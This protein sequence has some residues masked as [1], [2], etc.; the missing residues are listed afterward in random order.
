VLAQML[1]AH[2]QSRRLR[3]QAALGNDARDSGYFKEMRRLRRPFVVFR[4][5]A[6]AILGALG[7]GERR[8]EHLGRSSESQ[9]PTAVGEL[10]NLCPAPDVPQAFYEKQARE[11][12]RATRA[13]IR[14]LRR[15]PDALVTLTSRDAESAEIY[16]DEVTVREL[17]EEHLGNPGVRGVPC[18][19]ALMQELQDAVDGRTRST[20]D[21]LEDE[22]VYPVY[23]VV[24]A[25]RLRKDGAVYF[26]PGGCQIEEIYSS[27]SDL[28][29]ALREGETKNHRLVTDSDQ[30]VGVT[31]FKPSAACE[32]ELRRRLAE[33]ASR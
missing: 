14:E 13:L 28:E 18:Q 33:L 15:R 22:R 20:P 3:T 10:W 31:V 17:A 24:R 27:R 23:E 30:T 8:S 4:P 16:R 11:A 2:N 26:S 29:P 25:L 12:R 21:G 5:L 32:R 1:R 7:C 19:Q 6:R 9:L